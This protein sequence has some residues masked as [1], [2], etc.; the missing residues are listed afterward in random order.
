MNSGDIMANED[1]VKVVEDTLNKSIT[2][3]NT[4]SS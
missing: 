2:T 3:T 1:I 4:F